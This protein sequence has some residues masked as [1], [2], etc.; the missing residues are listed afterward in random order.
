MNR[1][2]PHARLVELAVR[3]LGIIDSLRL[4]L[5]AGMTALTGETGAGKTMVIGA[6]DLLLGGRADA[7]MVR[8]GADEA[9]IDGRF[10]VGGEEL[11]LSRVIPVTGRSRAYLNGRLATAAMLAEVT[12][13]LVDLHGQHAHQS[14]LHTGV[15]RAALDSFAGID[16]SDLINARSLVQELEGELI[17]MG[18]DR[19]AREREL[20]LLRFQISELTAAGLTDPNEDE[21]LDHEESALADAVAHR[22]S[23][24]L[25]AALLNDDGGATDQIR[26]ALAEL[27]GRPPFTDQETRLRT[28]LAEL[29]DVAADLR[30]TGEQLEDDPERL[31]SLRQRRQLLVDLRRKY[32]TASRTGGVAGLG[33]L[34]DVILYLED[35]HKRAAALEDHDSRA[36]ELETRLDAARSSLNRAQVAVGRARRKAAPALAAEVEN[37]LGP[38]AMARAKFSVQVPQHD[39]GD[40]ISFELAANPGLPAGPLAR[41]ASGGELARVML[42]LRLVVSGAP[43]I[44]VFDEVDAGIGGDAAAAVGRSLALLGRD[45]QVLVVTHLPQVAAYAHHQVALRKDHDR[46]V[47]AVAAVPLTAEDRIAEIARMLAGSS[48]GDSMRVAARELLASSTV[49]SP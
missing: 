46:K 19:G 42:A 10:E 26:R 14:L 13:P 39:P 17:A 43:P 22:T 30:M 47:A 7:S 44:L 31:D 27:A 1:P 24:A 9:I 28:L 34:D 21:R 38:L 48:S 6:I 16:L 35:C 45:H 12:E 32:G 49:V 29:A 40:E 37:Q 15:Q 25:A 23:G 4:E 8:P 11:I 41:V 2:E 36:S 20:D 3:D 33:T 5:S 18:G